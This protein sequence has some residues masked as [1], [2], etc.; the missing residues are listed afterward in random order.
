[1]DVSSP[2]V[3]TLEDHQ[4]LLRDPAPQL[5]FDQLNQEAGGRPSQHPEILL[6]QESLSE[7]CS[8]LISKFFPSTPGNVM[9]SS[10]L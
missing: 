1:M 10:T 5:H 8:L 9:V 4:G 6:S 7:Q 3:V 2:N